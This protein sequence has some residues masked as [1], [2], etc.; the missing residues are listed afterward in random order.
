MLNTEQI[1]GNI[2]NALDRYEVPGDLPRGKVRD[3]YI[4]PD[5]KR[6]VLITTDRLTVFD[7]PIGLVPY[8][9][10]VLNQLSAWWFG[11]TAKIIPNHYV[12]MPDPNVAIV[13]E[14]QPLPLEV[15]V[16]GYITG[17]TATSLWGQY[18]A[19]ARSMYGLSFPDGLKKNQMLPQPVITPTTK[20]TVGHDD[21]QMLT[22]V[23]KF[24]DADTWKRVRTAALALY[25]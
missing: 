12:D 22:D 14:T 25:Q 9:G 4:M 16:R 23:T 13:R 7:H 5:G 10:Q 17:V 20:S 3:F 24:V 18:A 6:R 2:S 15:I 11:R 8:K 19:G 1:M 21:R